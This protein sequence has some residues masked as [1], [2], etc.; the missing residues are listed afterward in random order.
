MFSRRQF[1]LRPSVLLPPPSE[2][3][4]QLAYMC[5]FAYFVEE[6]TI[7]GRQKNPTKTLMI[8]IKNF[9]AHR[10]S[11]VAFPNLQTVHVSRQQ[12]A[13]V[14][15]SAADASSGAGTHSPFLDKLRR[16]ETLLFIFPTL[17][18]SSCSASSPR[19]TDRW[20]ESQDAVGQTFPRR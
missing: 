16:G 4:R 7:K 14:H 13:S 1:V 12:R 3:M 11:F 5:L 15:L 6:I 9:K 18:E 17:S 2:V 10:C 8:K 20:L 19:R